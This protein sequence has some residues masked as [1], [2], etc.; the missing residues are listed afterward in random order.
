MPF[1]NVFRNSDPYSGM[2]LP[3]QALACYRLARLVTQDEITRGP[4]TRLADWLEAHHAAKAAYLMEC[5]FCVGV[6][7]AFAVL[8]LNRHRAGRWVVRA[9]AISGAQALLVEAVGALPDRD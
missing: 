5:A 2:D 8:L 1:R 7:A 3:V 4:R 6:W 9:L